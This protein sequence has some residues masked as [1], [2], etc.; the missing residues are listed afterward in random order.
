MRGESDG[1]RIWPEELEEKCHQL[2]G[3]QL[4]EKEQTEREEH[5]NLRSLPRVLILKLKSYEDMFGK[6]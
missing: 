1:A 2:R 5:V 4:Q 3:R 6:K